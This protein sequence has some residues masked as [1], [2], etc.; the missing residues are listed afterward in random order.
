MIR[1]NEININNCMNFTKLIKESLKTTSLKR[2]RIKVDPALVNAECDFSNCNGY[3]GYILHEKAK[4]LKILVLSPEM[5]IEDIPTEFLEI[6][7]K[8]EMCDTFE[9]FKVFLIKNLIKDGKPEND[10]VIQQ[11]MNSNCIDEVEQ[12]AKQS[13]YTGDNLSELYK[14]F[15]LTDEE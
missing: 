5:T 15:I 14:D 12:F 9:E 3:E 8:Q 2:V 4:S 6:L 11:I 1:Y 13:G 10:P 7:N